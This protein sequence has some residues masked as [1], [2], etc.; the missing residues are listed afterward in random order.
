MP[1]K[2]RDNS[3][4]AKH[5]RTIHFSLFVTCIGLV[6]LTFLKTQS[7]I[8]RAYRDIGRVMQIQ[9]G[10]GSNWLHKYASGLVKTLFE[11]SENEELANGH[12]SHA[13]I[14]VNFKDS[15]DFISQESRR[16]FLRIFEIDELVSN[17]RYSIDL[18]FEK[19]WTLFS[20]AKYSLQTQRKDTLML[21]TINTLNHFIDTWNDFSRPHYAYLLETFEDSVTVKIAMDFLGSE[22]TYT[23]LTILGSM[24]EYTSL[25]I[26]KKSKTSKYPDKKL[27]GSVEVIPTDSLY[28]LSV[29]FLSGS[30]LLKVRI[31]TTIPCHIRKIRLNA[32]RELRKMVDAE[33]DWP[34]GRFDRT[35]HDLNFFTRNIRSLPL[36]DIEKVLFS[37]KQRKGETFE[38]LG[39]KFPALFVTRWG[40]LIIFGLQLYFLLHLLTFENK[41]T[42]QDSAWE[43]PWI[44]L[45]NNKESRA[46]FFITAFI[47]PMLTCGVLI[48]NGIWETQK[49][50][51]L[52]YFVLGLGVS[53][54]LAYFS[55]QCIRK[56][57]ND[58]PKLD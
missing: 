36:E 22:R 29:S 23:S 33:T 26:I 5:L 38:F 58:N 19:R 6:A 43:V 8:E 41:I 45:Y 37:E 32:Q 40:I 9:A 4:L 11:N 25:T 44:G 7:D 21:D 30:D 16:Y 10:L 14:G 2:K 52:T 57:W 27:L 17:P 39:L 15:I 31:A 34:L 56:I 54:L 49:Y 47:L 55:S 24:R 35:F 42:P 48:F 3:E 20:T 51:N 28:F 1:T 46:T 50:L 12:A 53:I 18:C 13:C